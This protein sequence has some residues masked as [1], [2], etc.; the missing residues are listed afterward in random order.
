LDVRTRSAT[1]AAF[2]SGKDVAAVLM[3]PPMVDVSRKNLRGKPLGLVSFCTESGGR[4]AG[5]GC[6]QRGIL[7]PVRHPGRYRGP[8]PAPCDIRCTGPCY[9]PG[10]TGPSVQAHGK[11]A[12]ECFRIMLPFWSDAGDRHGW[13][14]E[15]ARMCGRSHRSPYDCGRLKNLTPPVEPSAASPRQTLRDGL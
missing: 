13:D 10:S 2:L 1:S 3:V 9:G 5:E 11:S 8:K 15:I 6:V 12:R 7:Q 14:K 4:G